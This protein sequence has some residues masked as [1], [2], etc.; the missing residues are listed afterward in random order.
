MNINTALGLVML[1]PAI[2]ALVQEGKDD[3]VKGLAGTLI[4]LCVLVCLDQYVPIIDDL[5]TGVWWQVLA[6]ACA[7]IATVL[8]VRLKNQVVG[9]LM[10]TGGGLLAL[11]HLAVIDV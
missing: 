4:V 2:V 3:A 6:V 1:V 8:V 9:T 10:V 11:I 7:I 5:I